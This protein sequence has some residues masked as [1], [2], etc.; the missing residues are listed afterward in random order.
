M[1]QRLKSHS[2][3]GCRPVDLNA[4]QPINSS[5][6][7]I[8]SL[9][10][11]PANGALFSN[12]KFPLSCKHP[13][14]MSQ[15]KREIG[16]RVLARA[17]LHTCSNQLR[18]SRTPL[19]SDP[20]SRGQSFRLSGRKRQSVLVNAN[21]GDFEY[22]DGDDDGDGGGA[23][24]GE[25]LDDIEF[26]FDAPE[27]DHDQDDGDAYADDEEAVNLEDEVSFFLLLIPLLSWS[28][29][30]SSPATRTNLQAILQFCSL[31]TYF[32]Y[33][34]R[35]CSFPSTF[36]SSQPLLLVNAFSVALPLE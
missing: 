27:G 13:L 26:E 25:G 12:S 8:P 21:G 3:A 20:I 22:D 24:D 30:P 36:S 4:T 34:M 18:L 10:R 31:T 14:L 32:A 5:G 9:P 17:G 11:L 16:S 33:V 35:C 1:A 29:L 28:F 15:S 19:S 23:L 7:S 2:L 6:H